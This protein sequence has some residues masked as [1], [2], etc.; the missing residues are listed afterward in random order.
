MTTNRTPFMKTRAMTHERVLSFIV[1]TSYP[2]AVAVLFSDINL[3]FVQFAYLF[4]GLGAALG[5][6]GITITGENVYL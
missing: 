3:G 2:A 1:G 6:I 4:I 5:L